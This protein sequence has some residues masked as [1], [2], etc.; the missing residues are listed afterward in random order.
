MLNLEKRIAIAEK[1]AALP[2]GTKEVA[3]FHEI[4]GE[5][6]TFDQLTTALAAIRLGKFAEITAAISAIPKEELEQLGPRQLFD[7]L[8]GEQVSREDF[9]NVWIEERGNKFGKPAE[10]MKPKKKA[11]EPAPK[12]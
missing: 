1:I 11:D 7:R 5:Q 10:K 9:R 2:D 12:S 4:Y 8:Y 6:V 3:A